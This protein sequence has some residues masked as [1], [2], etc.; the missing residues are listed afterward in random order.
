M[1]CVWVELY[2]GVTGLIRIWRI[3]NE[4]GSEKPL[5]V[6]LALDVSCRTGQGRVG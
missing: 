2:G 4:A 6:E 3:L 1:G 5:E